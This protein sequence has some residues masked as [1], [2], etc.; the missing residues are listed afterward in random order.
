MNFSEALD[1]IKEGEVML[2]MVWRPGRVVFLIPSSIF[3]PVNMPLVGL[4][5]QG[6]RVN[7]GA[8][9]DMRTPDHEVQVWSPQMDDI[10]AD[11][12]AVVD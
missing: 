2:R 7:Y 4:A 12:W 9:I 5:G 3:T 6:T 1:K 11:D 10:L 8:H